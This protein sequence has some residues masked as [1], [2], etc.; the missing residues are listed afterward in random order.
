MSK[1]EEEHGWT[2]VPRSMDKMLASRKDPKP[3]IPLKPADF[4]LPDSP[5]VKT[6]TAYAKETLPKET[7]HHSMRVYYYG[8]PPFSILL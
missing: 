7:F 5:M 8:K 3:P 6:V 1:V 2:P 4:P